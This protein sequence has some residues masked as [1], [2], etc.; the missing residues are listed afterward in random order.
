MCSPMERDCRRRIERDLELADVEATLEW[1]K[2]RRVAILADRIELGRRIIKAISGSGKPD[3]AVPVEAA[4]RSWTVSYSPWGGLRIA[5]VISADS[6]LFRQPPV[7]D[8]ATAI[9]PDDESKVRWVGDC[10]RASVN[11]VAIMRAVPREPVVRDGT[12]A[13][14]PDIDPVKGL[15]SLLYETRYGEDRPDIDATLD[16]KGNLT[17]EIQAEARAAKQAMV[18]D[19]VEVDFDGTFGL[20]DHDDF[21]PRCDDPTVIPDDDAHAV[22]EHQAAS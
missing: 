15:G 17:V 3:V 7:A 6:P 18:R 21:E 8:A 14:P 5:E 11:A 10:E 9:D 19:G 1:L 13:I 16:A 12:A 20:E 22:V 2:G 4:G